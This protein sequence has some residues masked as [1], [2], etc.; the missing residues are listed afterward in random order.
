M[1][2]RCRVLP[3][4]LLSV[5]LLAVAGCGDQTGTDKTDQATKLID[6]ARALAKKTSALE[7]QMDELWP[8][9][10]KIDP[11]K[12]A[13]DALAKLDDAEADYAEMT[14]NQESVAAL[15]GK[16]AKLDVGEELRTWAGQQKEIAELSLQAT[17]VLDEFVAKDKVLFSLWNQLDQADREKLIQELK[18]LDARS[19]KLRTRASKMQQASEK[20]YKDNGLG[21]EA[22]SP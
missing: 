15:Y 3:A 20:Y 11:A 18:D 19:L 16:V 7:K 5:L 14:K 13:T 21:E 9:I 2:R 1:P 4:C 17:A 22:G 6:Q 12:N 10:G 8:K